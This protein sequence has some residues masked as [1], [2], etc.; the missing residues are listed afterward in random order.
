VLLITEFGVVYNATYKKN[1]QGQN[2]QP[3][4]PPSAKGRQLFS[5]QALRPG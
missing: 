3:K 5:L 1:K 2:A 4:K